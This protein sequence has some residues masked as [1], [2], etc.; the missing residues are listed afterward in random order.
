MI[1]RLLFW[2][3]ALVFIASCVN[4]KQEKN[5]DEN[6]TKSQVEAVVVNPADFDS[7]AAELVGKT[8]TMEGLVAHACAHGG[9]RFFIT[10]EKG[11]VRIKVELGDD[12]AAVT[13]ELEGDMVK[14]SGSVKELRIDEDYLAEWEAEVEAKIAENNEK[15]DDDG[16]GLHT[17]EEGHEDATSNDELNKINS[18]REKITASGSD[19]L[20]Y[21]SI[22]YDKHEVLKEGELEEAQKNSEDAEQGEE[23]DNDN[24]GA[25]E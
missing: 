17:G 23:H 16:K 22:E 11:D 15:H 2:S 24:D 14:V 21:Y 13:T 20:S 10:D 4:T 19:H 8:I 6:Q 5:A 12:K 3:L 25:E 18:L 7:L 1:K 9:K